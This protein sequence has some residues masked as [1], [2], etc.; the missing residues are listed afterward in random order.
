MLSGDGI[1]HFSCLSFDTSSFVEFNRVSVCQIFIP[2]L[3][4]QDNLFI[5]I[6]A[7]FLSIFLTQIRTH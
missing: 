4:W 1:S 3:L 7:Y 6:Y 2:D 5:L